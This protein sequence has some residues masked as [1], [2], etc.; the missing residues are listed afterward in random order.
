VSREEP[1]AAAETTPLAQDNAPVAGSGSAMNAGLYE[2]AQGTASLNA[3]PENK[4]AESASDRWEGKADRDALAGDQA[5][6]RKAAPSRGITVGTDKGA[7]KELES[8]K[9]AKNDDG[10]GFSG[11]SEPGPGGASSSGAGGVTTGAALDRGDRNEQQIYAQPP[12]P[13]SAAP[14]RKK[15]APTATATV[16][17]APEP[18]ADAKKAPAKV[19]T[20]TATTKAAPEKPADAPAAKQE[21]KPDS[22]LIAWAKGEH[23]RAVALAQKGECTAAAK[24]A[25]GV[26]SRASDYYAQYMATD[27][28]LKQCAQYI[29]AE[30][31]KDAERSAKSRA[32]K[33][34]N[35][36]ESPAPSQTK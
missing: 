30:R 1:A 12:P 26:S 28:A 8:A 20:S 13:P 24:L 23:A 14:N 6:L 21:A 32:Q 17:R 25:L 11:T 33:R 5:K 22:S 29:N 2:G 9:G 31:D 34:T 10:F 36:D 4:A 15:S 3:E 27:R 7:V 19:A 18:V 16:P 35:A